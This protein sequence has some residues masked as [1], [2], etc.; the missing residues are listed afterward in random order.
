MPNNIITS[1]DEIK[2]FIAVQQSTTIETMQ[3]YL[4]EAVESVLPI[5]GEA[6]WEKLVTDYEQNSVDADHLKLLAIAQKAI[7]NFAYLQYSV[8]GNLSISDAGIQ[9]SDDTYSK[10]AY[11]WAVVKFQRLRLEKAWSSLHQ[12]LKL[13]YSK[14]DV[15]T[16]WAD[17]DEA[18]NI[19][20]FYIYTVDDFCLYRPIADYSTLWALRP[21]MLSVDNNSITPLI[22]EAL[23]T[24]IKVQIKAKNLS[25]DNKLLLKKIQSAVAHLSIAEAI[26][27]LRFLST[28]KGLYVESIEAQTA[29]VEQ[30][31]PAT[32]EANY[33]VKQDAEKK[34]KAA[35]NVLKEFLNQNASAA[36]YK[37]YYNSG[38]F[39]ADEEQGAY[40][41][42]TTT[43]FTLGR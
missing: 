2:T 21:C 4:D 19:L 29:N 38:N 34:G 33:I 6:Q 15:Y 12:I 3:P 23:A 1:V 31:S 37:G 24:E 35:L 22:S 18:D 10:R 43:I 26:D 16:D 5:I 7:V 32:T 27:S 39:N 42:T 17:S 40:S 30:V 13:L 9:Q 41:N 28:N 8:D 36:K 20:Q 14:Q 11:Q 25:A